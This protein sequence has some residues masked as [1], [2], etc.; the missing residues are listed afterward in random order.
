MIY[1]FVH[2]KTSYYF[3]NSQDLLQ[4]AKNKCHNCGV[5]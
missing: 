5:K 2:I 3:F 4:K 1:F